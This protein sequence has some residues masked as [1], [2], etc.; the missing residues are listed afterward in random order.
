MMSI[1]ECCRNSAI[2]WSWEGFSGIKSVFSVWFSSSEL[3]QL[4]RVMW[5]LSPFLVATSAGVYVKKWGEE[6]T[7]PIF[8]WK[9]G[10]AFTKQSGLT[11]I[12]WLR[13]VQDVIFHGHQWPESRDYQTFW[14]SNSSRASAFSLSVSTT[15]WWSG[16][17]T[18]KSYFS[19]S[20][21]F[22]SFSSRL[23]WPQLQSCNAWEFTC[24]TPIGKFLPLWNPPSSEVKPGIHLACK[25]AQKNAAIHLPG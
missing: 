23:K 5:L 18:L 11:G 19:P 15:V 10:Q 7:M 21:G 9:E 24:V 6:K 2:F 3:V 8:P 22:S 14:C 4:F 12:F 1:C 16:S 20:C 25:S 17:S 13:A